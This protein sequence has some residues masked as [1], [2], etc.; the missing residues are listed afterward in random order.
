MIGMLISILVLL[1]IVGLLVWAVT[2]LAPLGIPQPVLIVLQILIILIAVLY[3]LH[4][5]GVVPA[6]LP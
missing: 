4:F 1:L 5:V 2:L 6:R 3:L